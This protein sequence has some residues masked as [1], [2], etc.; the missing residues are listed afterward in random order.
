MQLTMA[1]DRNLS[2]TILKPKTRLFIEISSCY[3]TTPEINPTATNKIPTNSLGMKK[4]SETKTKKVTGTVHVIQPIKIASSK[5]TGTVSQ[6]TNHQSSSKIADISQVIKMSSSKKTGRVSQ[7][8][9]LPS[10]SKRTYVS[11]PTM[12]NMS[13]TARSS[14]T[15]TIVS[16]LAKRKV[17]KTACPVTQRTQ[18]TPHDPTM[19]QIKS[20]QET[21][22]R[23]QSTATTSA[24]RIGSSSNIKQW[25]ELARTREG[26]MTV[27]QVLDFG[28]Q[29]TT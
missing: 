29:K 21:T 15:S 11:Q 22:N 14:T 1:G 10:S 23:K 5:T 8:T 28:V 2:C 25:S 9:R 3:P 4:D 27:R 17:N 7:P 19:T 24:T 6:I 12:V 18:I 20:T 13:S 26:N 16:Q